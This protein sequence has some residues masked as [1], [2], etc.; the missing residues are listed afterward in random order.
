MIS[1]PVI[2]RLLRSSA[3]LVAYYQAITWLLIGIFG[4]ADYPGAPILRNVLAATQVFGLDV[5]AG[6]GWCC[7]FGGGFVIS[8]VALNRWSGLTLAGAPVLFLANGIALFVLLVVLR[9]GLY[10]LRA[11]R[12][13]A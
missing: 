6:L 8:D 7:G 12:R 10:G 3:I 9:L 13:P 5:L 2:I 11:V 4:F 1:H